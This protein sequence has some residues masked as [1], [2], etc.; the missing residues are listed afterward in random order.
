ML[1]VVADSPDLSEVLA[2]AGVDGETLG[3]L[4]PAVVG[5]LGLGVEMVAQARTGTGPGLAGLEREL[6][7]EGWEVLRLLAQAVSDLAG[8]SEVRRAGGVLGSDG[9]RRTR[10]ESGHARGVGTVEGQITVS[11][12]AYRAAGVGNLHPADEVLGL[13]AGLY[14]PGLACLRAREAVRGSFVQ[15]ADAVE[16]ATGHNN[17]GALLRAAGRRGACPGAM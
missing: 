9:I 12:L 7:V 8:R 13:P 11:R 5:L 6:Q 15:A 14:S 17:A 10:V 2:G 4:V 1:A 3:C 16:R